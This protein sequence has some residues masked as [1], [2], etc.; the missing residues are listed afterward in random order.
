[1]L[2]LAGFE[3]VTTV[4]EGQKLQISECVPE[5]QR[6]DLHDG[7]QPM[8]S[9]RVRAVTGLFLRL[10]HSKDGSRYRVF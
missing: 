5:E 3:P 1:M 7:E 8:I 2:R 9:K 4:F 6:L 10:Q